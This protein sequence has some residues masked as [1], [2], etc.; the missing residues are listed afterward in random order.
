MLF[1]VLYTLWNPTLVVANNQLIL[2]FVRRK[3]IAYISAGPFFDLA[4]DY[5]PVAVTGAMYLIA[6]STETSE[7][8]LNSWSISLVDY[9]Q[10]IIDSQIISQTLFQTCP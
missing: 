3:C 9:S 1:Y 5:H 7:V 6:Q 10:V 8:T 2:S 4:L